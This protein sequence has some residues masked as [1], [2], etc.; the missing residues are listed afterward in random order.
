MSHL[1]VTYKNVSKAAVLERTRTDGKADHLK[2]N[3]VLEQTSDFDKIMYTKA[4]F[5]L[6]TDRESVVQ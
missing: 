3:D 6:M 4:S 2:V 1:D 5:P